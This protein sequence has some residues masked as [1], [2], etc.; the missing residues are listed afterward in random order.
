[1]L[2]IKRAPTETFALEIKEGDIIITESWVP[3]KENVDSIMIDGVFNLLP[4]N[5]RIELLDWAW[6]SLV[7][8]GQLLLKVPNW[9]H[10]RA[11]M[12]PTC[13]WPPICAEFFML[14]NK[15]FRTL[16]MPHVNMKC[17]FNITAAFGF[18]SKDIFV[19]MRNEETQASLLARNINT[20]T[21]YHISLTKLSV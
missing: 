18:D 13:V 21:E 14:A 2:E 5:K 17:N 3:E 1:M 11:Y 19:S 6:K 15:E 12:D 10:S 4:A 8:N 9:S 20:C 16:N 7:D